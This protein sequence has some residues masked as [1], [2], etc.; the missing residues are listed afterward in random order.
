MGWLSD[1][2]SSH[3]CR[4]PGF[5]RWVGKIPLEK[6]MATHASNLAWKIPWTEEPGQLVLGVA[7]S[8]TLLS[9]WGCS[10]REVVPHYGL[11]CISLMTS[12]TSQGSLR[13]R[14]SWQMHIPDLSSRSLCYVYSQEGNLSS[15]TL[16]LVLNS[17]FTISW[18][19]SPS[20]IENSLRAKIMVF[21]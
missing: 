21:V 8:W 18:F 15:R 19:T 9:N 12:D 11:I 1:K 13:L 4:R 10:R 3:Q 20:E 16:S 17:I 5:D 14:N 2:E 6:E 7:K